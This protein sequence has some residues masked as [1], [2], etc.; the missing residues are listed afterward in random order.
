MCPNR[1]E[2]L[3]KVGEDALAFCPNCGLAVKRI[4]SK[5]AFEVK[6]VTSESKAAAKGFTTFKRA[7]RGVWEKTAGEGPDL[8]VGTPEDMAA[9]EAESRPKK[10]LDLDST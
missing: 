2:V 7:E 3:Q 8:I 1:V 6:K 10:V 5:P 9:V 4:V